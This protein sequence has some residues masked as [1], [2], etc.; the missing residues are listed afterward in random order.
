VLSPCVQAYIVGA[1]SAARHY[2]HQVLTL[3]PDDGPTHVLLDYM[4]EYDA[5]VDWAGYRVLSEK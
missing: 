4:K 1:W 3:Q 2:L 5:P